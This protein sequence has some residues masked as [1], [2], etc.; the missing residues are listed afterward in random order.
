[1]IIKIISAQPN[2][3][4]KIG[5]QEMKGERINHPKILQ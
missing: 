5:K 2:T 4:E 3:T 1:M